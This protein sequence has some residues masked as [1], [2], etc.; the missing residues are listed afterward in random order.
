MCNTTL[1]NNHV[2]TG[3]LYT[4][5]T[6]HFPIFHID[7]S[8]STRTLPS[9]F[10]TRLYTQQNLD[11]FSLSLRNKDWSS[12]LSC[13]D[14]QNAYSSFSNE[15]LSLYNDCFPLKTVR[16]GYKNRKPWLSEGLKKSI[17]TKNRL[18]R[19][20][21]K[22]KKNDHELLYKRYRNKLHGLLLKAEKDHYEKLLEDNKNN[23][24][25]S[26]RILKDIINKKKSSSPCSRFYINRNITTDKKVIANGFNSFFVNVGPNLANSK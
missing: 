22:I 11:K 14:P 2:L 8:S 12:I 10:K 3:I 18:F 16:N 7:N 20:H 4:D 17:K 19:R 15:Y 24:K 5:I 25:N 21:M 23:L 26:W 6:D 9:M 13:D 1:D